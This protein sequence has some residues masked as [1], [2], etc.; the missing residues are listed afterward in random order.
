MGSKTFSTLLMLRYYREEGINDLVSN[1]F[2]SHCSKAYFDFM[3]LTSSRLAVQLIAE[4]VDPR[5]FLNPRR[6]YSLSRFESYFGLKPAQF[7]RVCGPGLLL[8]DDNHRRS[9]LLLDI[10]RK[11]PA[12]SFVLTETKHIRS[13]NVKR[14]TMCR[15][16]L[17]FVVRNWL[18]ELQL[19]GYF[20]SGKFFKQAGNEDDYRRQFKE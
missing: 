10:I 11:L 2:N 18:T 12:S 13:E 20:D 9:L 17:G 1:V 15:L 3:G 5:W 7:Q 14:V 6:P 4:I 19:A 16:V 8:V